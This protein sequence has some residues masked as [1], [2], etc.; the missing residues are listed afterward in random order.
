MNN[1]E[2]L[3][4]YLESFEHTGIY[5]IDRETLVVY[6]E[7][8]TAKKYTVKDRIGQPCYLVHGNKS[9]CYSCPLRNKDR[10]TY[11]TREDHGMVFSVSARETMWKGI[12]TYTITV[13]K[14]KEL[15]KRNTLSEE[16]L[17]RMNRALHSSIISY[18]DINM[19]TE[20]CQAIHF[21][22]N[23]EHRI[24]N[25]SYE[26][27]FKNIC[28]RQY[29]FEED[30]IRSEQVLGIDNLRRISEDSEGENE[31]STR[32]RI[33][34]DK[35]QVHMLEST[36]Y[37]LRDELPHHISIIGKEVTQD[38]KSKIQL[39]LYTKLV[40]NAVTTYQLNLSQN[41]FQIVVGYDMMTNRVQNKITKCS[42]IDELYEMFEQYTVGD[43]EK[44]KAFAFFDRKGQIAL[45]ES[46]QSIIRE[47]LPID[48]DDGTFMWMDITCN[49]LKNPMTGDIEA[50][51]YAE[52]VDQDV[53]SENVINQM[54][55]NDYDYLAIFDLINHTNQVFSNNDRYQKEELED[56]LSA[57]NREAYF[58]RIYA[59]DD[60]EA[61]IFHNSAEYIRQQ[62]TD[63]DKF[64]NFYY[65]YEKDGTVSYKKETISY[66]NGDKRYFVMSRTDNTAAVKKQKEMND[67]LITALDEAKRATEEKTEL[68]A[69]M[70]HDLRT[71]M[72]GILGMTALSKNETDINVMLNNMRRID[73]AGKYML[74]M[75]NDT[76]DMKR[77][78][79]GNLILNPAPDKCSFFIENLQEMIRPTI[80]DKK[81]TFTVIN[82]NIDLNR[83]ALFDAVRMKQIFTNIVSNSVKFTPEG[84]T[85][86]FKMECLYN[87]NNTDH[88]CFEIIDTGIGMSREFIEEK[89]FKPY[90]QENNQLTDLYPGPGLGLAITK[91][92]VDLMGGRIEAESEP[93]EGTT[94]RVY[95]DIKMLS[96]SQAMEMLDKKK[97]VA[98]NAKK[99]LAG[100]KI[101]LCEDH[102]LNA[103]ISRKILEMVGCNVVWAQNGRIG[104]EFF[105]NSDKYSIDAILMDIKMPEMDGIA[106]TKY[107]RS[108]LRPDAKIVPIIAMTA[109][110]FDEDIKT[111]KD[112]GMNEHL[113][114]P[115]VA[116]TLYETLVKYISEK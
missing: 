19:S 75:I 116:A 20:E 10:I 104:A 88:D 56:N 60:V 13:E 93:G 115:V 55:E 96:D 30:I 5:I 39:S 27:Y 11:V 105:E 61:F 29:V 40:S 38:E 85:I 62:L 112:A 23:G 113:A 36:A 91:S 99:I 42:N 77:I 46:N 71:P 73:A 109:N 57:K 43:E 66:L 100:K 7:N 50:I 31:T 101:L 102:P 111:S 41:S 80:E 86:V 22:E 44:K 1:E 95:L 52:T 64:E 92:L 84:G 83:Y 69:R 25:M 82:K 2:E 8:R 9:M 14:S 12:P 34:D 108:L 107:I 89:L 97:M 58:R 67:R 54:I 32:F 26:E 72:N 48:M 47:R 90:A 51:L 15:P 114:K 53:I 103:E 37:I 70:S 78:E 79:T 74:R 98:V 81:I 76:L 24:Y 68:F 63:K 59:G 33:K 17:E 28:A 49:M 110:A 6:Y 45:F 21:A 94:M 3:I 4:E 106:A 35:G 87:D 65:M 16:S 18:V